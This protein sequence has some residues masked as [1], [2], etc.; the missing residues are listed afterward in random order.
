MWHKK[1]A[2]VLDKNLPGG[3]FDLTM[4]MKQE[5]QIIINRRQLERDR[6]LARLDPTAYCADRCIATGNCD[7]YEDYFRL[8]PVEVVA[9]CRDCILGDG[10]DPC[11]IPPQMLEEG[12]NKLKP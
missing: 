10:D 7:V 4:D 1:N 9:F 6:R 11:D 12:L 8:S 2:H 3:V 5:E